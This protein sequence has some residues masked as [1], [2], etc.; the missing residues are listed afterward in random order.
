MIL[1]LFGRVVVAREYGLRASSSRPVSI[2]RCRTLFRLGGTKQSRRS[3]EL[4]V[5]TLHLILDKTVAVRGGGDAGGDSVQAIADFPLC[6]GVVFALSCA[7]THTLIAT[8]QLS[9]FLASS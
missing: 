7:T 6:N 3:P 1:R 2:V 9:P 5:P 8:L 4:N